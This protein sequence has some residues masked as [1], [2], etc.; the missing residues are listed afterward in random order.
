M[1]T[2]HIFQV[3]YLSMLDIHIRRDT[4]G[5]ERDKP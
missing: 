4:V 1:D 3:D 2:N 5:K